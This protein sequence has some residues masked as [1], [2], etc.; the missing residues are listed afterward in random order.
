M[1]QNSIDNSK[2]TVITDYMFMLSVPLV[3]A[4]F[5]HGFSAVLNVA[6]SVITC[7]V[8]TT[9][10][11]KLL[12][13]EF[14][15]KSPH[16]YV[17]GICVALLLPAS[18]PW[19]MTMLTASFAMGVCVLPFG[20]PDNAPFAP[21][22]AAICFATL[23][24]PQDVF[25]Y[26]D[27][28]SSIGEMLVYGNSIGSNVISIL[29]VLVGN[30]PSAMGTGCII[31]FF[32]VLIF[33]TIRRPK[34]SI[35]VFSFLLTICTM[36]L[37]FPRVSV[38]RTISLVMELSSGMTVFGA[39]FFLSNPSFSPKRPLSKLVWGFVGGIICMLVRYV[40]PIE[41]SS[42]FSFLI[43]CAISDFFD[44]LPL[45][46]RERKIIESNEPYIDILEEPVATTVVPDEILDEIPDFSD[47][48]IVNQDTRFEIT[49][50]EN[51]LTPES[52]S[53]DA[54]VSVENTVT[55]QES[56]FIMGG[57]NNE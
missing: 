51:T 54:V 57:D 8:F 44:K 28:G 1:P 39:I 17:I 55:A 21:S 53:L 45:T 35:P 31:A 41:D 42:C 40:S 25:H 10:G 37:L 15:H 52:E 32:G 18:S 11:K 46:R 33:L 49:I 13:I 36:S 16:T 12:K 19:W 30:V 29:E 7:L 56:P 20:S 2:R 27:F 26:S 5:I 38:G 24:W 23:C 50:E 9:I 48:E 14:P 34:D 22:V 6:I 3:V 47:E 4:V 43:I